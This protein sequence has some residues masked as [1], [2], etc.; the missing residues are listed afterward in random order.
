[1]LI[2]TPFTT[3]EEIAVEY[4]PDGTITVKAALRTLRQKGVLS[5]GITAIPRGT[6]GRVKG[7]VHLYSSL[8]LLAVYLNRQGELKKAIRAAKAAAQL[9]RRSSTKSIAWELAGLRMQRPTLV[10]LQRQLELAA[11]NPEVEEAIMK[12]AEETIDKRAKIAKT[13]LD[14]G[15]FARVVKLHGGLIELMIPDSGERLS[16]PAGNVGDAGMTLDPG[17]ALVL[18]WEPWGPGRT[19]LKAEPALDVGDD[20]AGEGGP[21]YPFERPLPSEETRVALAGAIETLP[22]VRRPRRIKIRSSA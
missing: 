13:Y 10:G 20:D 11:R 4:R 17:S 8:N 14:T 15:V 1:V 21:I 2:E 12:V 5:P 16:I 6:T 9:E 19:L 18:R 3:A 22:Q 7:A